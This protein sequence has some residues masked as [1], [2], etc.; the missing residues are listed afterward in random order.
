MNIDQNVVFL[1]LQMHAVLIK[2]ISV[3]LET[4]NN[5]HFIVLI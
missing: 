5:K 3:Q 4:Y 2:F 1:L